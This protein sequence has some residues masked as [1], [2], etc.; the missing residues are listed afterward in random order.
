ML[1][2]S[3]ILLSQ[4]YSGPG[5]IAWK[6]ITRKTHRPLQHSAMIIVKLERKEILRQS[7]RELHSV[8]EKYAQCAC[9]FSVG[10]MAD[11]MYGHQGRERS[12]SE[13]EQFQENATNFLTFVIG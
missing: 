7:R 13:T 8:N 5:D 3:S 1:A 6:L 10:K 12:I 4:L 9:M 2:M 11:T